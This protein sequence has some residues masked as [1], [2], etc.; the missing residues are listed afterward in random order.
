MPTQYGSHFFGQHFHEL[1]ITASGMLGADADASHTADTLF[2]LCHL[3][4]GRIN[5]TNGTLPCAQAATGTII[6]CHWLERSAVKD[7]VGSV[8]S[9]QIKVCELICIQPL[10]N[11]L[12]EG[13]QL[14]LVFSI[15]TSRGK[16]AENGM[17]RHCRHRRNAS[18]SKSFQCVLQLGQGVLPF[19][20]AIHTIQH[21]P[22]SIACYVSQAFKGNSRH[23]SAIGG[24]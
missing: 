18:E 17:F 8:A 24:N 3:G 2:H 5:G 4:I 9:R 6:I 10:L 22:C 20:V 1:G 21:R 11:P 12:A 23:S 19:T 16:L 13:C 14:S 7:L 15:G